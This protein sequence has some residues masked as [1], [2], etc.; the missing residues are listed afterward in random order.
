MGVGEPAADGFS[1][2]SCEA[3]DGLYPDDGMLRAR[4]LAGAE[5]LAHEWQA[6]SSLLQPTQP[7]RLGVHATVSLAQQ[8]I[9]HDA[10]VGLHAKLARVFKAWGGQRALASTQAPTRCGAD[11]A[12]AILLRHPFGSGLHSTV[13]QL[14]SVHYATAIAAAPTATLKMP[15]EA[16]ATMSDSACFE[17]LADAR[18]VACIH[19]RM[20][21][22]TV[23]RIHETDQPDVYKYYPDS[24]LPRLAPKMAEAYCRSMVSSGTVLHNVTVLRMDV[25]VPLPDLELFAPNIREVELS[26]PERYRI[27]AVHSLRK[28]KALAVLRHRDSSGYTLTTLPSVALAGLEDMSALS[29]LE[30]GVQI[31]QHALLPRGIQSIACS[32]VLAK[33]E[34]LRLNLTQPLAAQ[35]PVLRRASRCQLELTLTGG[36]PAMDASQAHVLACMDG[37]CAVLFNGSKVRGAVDLQGVPVSHS[38]QVARLMMGSTT[39]GA[40]SVV[41]LVARMLPNLAELELGGTC[42]SNASAVVQRAL[43]EGLLRPRL[44][45][46]DSNAMSQSDAFRCVAI[47]M[48]IELQVFVG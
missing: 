8:R 44:L 37:S 7:C 43:W 31:C 24:L 13:A 26:L 34:P 39:E 16:L 6:L 47:G 11:H 19:A 23:L 38:V 3:Q 18:Q 36:H 30:L 9:L 45:R 21:G 35:L 15:G 22:A 42:S 17:C 14:S 10:L 32:R 29:D 4:A 27:K 40:E 41:A 1:L 5:T 12:I 33:R 48:G 46:V 2:A 28:L 20:R 25:D